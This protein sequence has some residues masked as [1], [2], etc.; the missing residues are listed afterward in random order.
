ME[1]QKKGNKWLIVSI[2]ILLLAC[3]GMGGFIFVNKD[4]LTSKENTTTVSNEKKK[5]NEKNEKCN[6]VSYDLKTSE[7]GL[8]ASGAGISVSID[9][10]RKSVRISFNGMTISNT[11]GLGW[12]TGADAN[13]YELID[14]KTFDKKIS[15][16]LID[17][18][19]QD[20]TNSTILYLMEDGTVEYVPILKEINTNW[21][22]PDNTKKFNSYGKLN[23]ISDIVSLIPA[24][25]PGYHTVLARKADGTVINLA[26]TFKET[27]NFR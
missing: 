18:S 2:V 4:K 10:T 12:V 8:G 19:G 9:N 6:E 26:E 16:V 5:E 23:N 11:F 21:Q 13:S 14:T 1:S 22:Q 27:G 25:A 20:A 24:E 7:Y 3:I 17:G 15:Q